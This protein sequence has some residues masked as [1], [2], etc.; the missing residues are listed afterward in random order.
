MEKIPKTEKKRTTGKKNEVVSTNQM[1]R[2]G[3]FGGTDLEKITQ[4]K[5]Q[6]VRNKNK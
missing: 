6:N 3:L 5:N 2:H 1:T 4:F